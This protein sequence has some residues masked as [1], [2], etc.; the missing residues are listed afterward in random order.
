MR[1]IVLHAPRG[2]GR[3]RGVLASYTHDL[4]ASARHFPRTPV[5]GRRHRRGRADGCCV[6]ARVRRRRDPVAAEPEPLLGYAPTAPATGSMLRYDTEYP[7]IPYTTGERTDRV[8]GLI[9]RLESGEAKL[10]YDS[11][12]GYLESLLG[13]ARDRRLFADAG[14]LAD[15]PAKPPHRSQDAACDLLQRR[16]VHRL[17]SGRADRDRGPSIRIWAP[18][19][20]LLE[21]TPAAPAFSAELGRCLSCHD[22]YS[23]TGGGVRASSWAPATRA[24]RARSSR[25]RAGS[26]SPTAR[27]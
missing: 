13:R 1:G 17:R 8:A 24:R 16:R 19:F 9:D 6:M 3:G 27:R 11:E 20:Y 12:R 22:S 7:T 25:T 23:L 14:V 15:E 5:R 10:E 18:S 2:H 4:A 26:S 21:Q